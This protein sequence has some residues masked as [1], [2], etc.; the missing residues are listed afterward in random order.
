MPGF[1]LSTSCSCFIQNCRTEGRELVCRECPEIGQ[2]VP[3]NIGPFLK[4][5]AGL[6]EADPVRGHRGGVMARN[7]KATW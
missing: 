1:I 3:D 6:L 2:S 4:A 5:K 7:R